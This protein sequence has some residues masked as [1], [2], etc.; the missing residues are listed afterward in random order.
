[1]PGFVTE[2]R[3]SSAAPTSALVCRLLE[4]RTSDLLIIRNQLSGI[5]ESL[6][7]GQRLLTQVAFRRCLLRFE[8]LL[9]IQKAALGV[10]P[11]SGE[12][13]LLFS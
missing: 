8:D 1:L 10:L 9:L 5:V 2:K 11:L 12:P 13:R 6:F 3:G 4:S 7:Y